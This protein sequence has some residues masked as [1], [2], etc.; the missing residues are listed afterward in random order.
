MGTP[1]RLAH[2]SIIGP[3]TQN[4]GLINHPRPITL[5][6]AAHLGTFAPLLSSVFPLALNAP[7]GP[8]LRPSVHARNKPDSDLRPG[9]TGLLSG[10]PEASDLTWPGAGT[11]RGGG[12][13]D[14]A[15][16]TSVAVPILGLKTPT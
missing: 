16:G 2:S 13:S 14:A 3:Q 7:H 1:S 6:L 5:Q 9:L 11:G 15:G 12:G 10:L 4:M 8:G